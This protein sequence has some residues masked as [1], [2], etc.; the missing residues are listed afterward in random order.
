LDQRLDFGI[1]RGLQESTRLKQA[2]LGTLENRLF[3]PAALMPAPPPSALDAVTGLPLALL[4]EG[5]RTRRDIE[6]ACLRRGRKPDLR[7]ECNTAIQLASVIANHMA[8]GPLPELARTQFDRTKVFDI[9]LS[10]ILR[11]EP[12]LCL[13]W[14]P[15]TLA[16]SSSLEALRRSLISVLSASL[17]E[18]V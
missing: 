10:G 14:N 13:V 5:S 16:M 7:Y 2:K 6:K 9:G 15:R 4:E 11:K 18:K 12:P 8:A 17:P 3:I 1:V